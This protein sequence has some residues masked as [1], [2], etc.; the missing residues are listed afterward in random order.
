[1]TFI[2]WYFDLFQEI[3]NDMDQYKELTQKQAAIVAEYLIMKK[4]FNS[5]FVYEACQRWYGYDRIKW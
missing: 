4:R 5:D 1:M 2:R 3:F